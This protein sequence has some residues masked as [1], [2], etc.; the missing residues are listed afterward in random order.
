[1]LSLLPGL[2]FAAP[3]KVDFT[4]DIK[5]FMADTCFACHGLDAKARKGGLRL[6]LREEALK[7]GKSE[8]LAIVP[9]KPE[10]SEAV[11]RVFT[12]D[13][14]DLMPPEKSHKV[15]TAR[16]KELFRRWVAEGAEYQGHWAFTAPKRP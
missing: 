15:L 11:R 10:L 2:L 6:D 12:S 8:K 7:A 13:A 9:G 16:Q 1:M 14:D 5:P 4:R 3:A